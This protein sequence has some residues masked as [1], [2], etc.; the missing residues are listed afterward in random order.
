[1]IDDL[2]MSVGNNGKYISK[3]LLAPCSQNK[4]RNNC[5]QCSVLLLARLHIIRRRQKHMFKF[6]LH[7]NAAQT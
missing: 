3:R 1:M 7:S 4:T 6:E 2:N 5:R